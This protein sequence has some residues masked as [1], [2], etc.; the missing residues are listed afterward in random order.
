MKN[1]HSKRHL[2]HTFLTSRVVCLCII[3]HVGNLYLTL[4]ETVDCCDDTVICLWSR[5]T[6]NNEET[7]LLDFLEV[8][9]RMLPQFRENLISTML[10]ISFKPQAV[11]NRLT[12]FTLQV[13]TV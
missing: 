3:K 7:F 4:S 12:F 8:V 6:I 9:K 10:C 13:N 5:S 11:S 2:L 1:D